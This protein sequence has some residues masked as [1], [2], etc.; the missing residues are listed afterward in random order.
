MTARDLILK[1]A[2]ARLASSMEAESRK[3]MMRCRACDAE[4][5]VWDLGGLRYKARGEPTRMI[6]CPGCGT[7]SLADTYRKHP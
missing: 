4:R 2:P 3:W 7:R 6:R 1:I 5:S